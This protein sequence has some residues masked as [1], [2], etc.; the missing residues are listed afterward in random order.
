MYL[1]DC[2][3]RMIDMAF[4]IWPIVTVTIALVFSYFSYSTHSST[5]L[6]P[7]IAHHVSFWHSKLSLSYQVLCHRT[8]NTIVVVNIWRI[9][10]LLFT[11]QA[12]NETF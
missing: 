4:A 7:Y 9:R 2:D 6:K 5:S 1:S 10:S 8:K 12:I 11:L 3:L